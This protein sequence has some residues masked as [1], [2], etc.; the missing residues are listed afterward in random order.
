MAEIEYDQALGGGNYLRF[1][2]VTEKPREVADFTVQYE[3][4]IDGKTYP[5]VR[6][7]CAHGFAHR[8]TLDHEG[9]N[10]D[11]W[12]LGALSYKE[13]L[14]YAIRDLRANWRQYR[15]DFVRRMP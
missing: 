2:I 5:V 7:D 8:D 6:Y 11:K 4:V 3:V 10:H 14:Q 13:A 12:P 1:R 15:E 9:H